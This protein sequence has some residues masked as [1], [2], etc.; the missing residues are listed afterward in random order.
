M[1][2]LLCSLLL[3]AGVTVTLPP[4]ASVSGT[5]LSL[6]AF[7]TIEG[8]D[9][10]LVARIS[11]L[12]LGYAP[13]PGFSRVLE[14]NA[15]LN[16]VRALA[17]GMAVH[18]AGAKTCRVLPMTEHIA[19][20]DIT[21][22]A[23]ASLEQHL[24]GRGFG[25]CTLELVSSAVA[26]EVPKGNSACVLEVAPQPERPG[27][28]PA[29]VAVRLIVDGQTYRTA[30]TSWKVQ[31]WRQQ[32]VLLRDVRAGEVIAADMIELRRVPIDAGLTASALDSTQ[33]LGTAAARPLQAGKMLLSSD[34]VRPLVVKQGDLVIL[35]VESG[36]I[37][38]RTSATAE[39]AG[40]VG[41][42]IRVIVQESGREISALVVSR[43][44][45]RI[46][47]GDRQPT[48]ERQ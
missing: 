16:Q 12:K 14:A 38:V 1:I 26:I 9:A 18:L 22:A 21:K 46:S 17:P 45:V 35:V 40:A 36:A 31:S 25:D 41:D 33:V 6:G 19:A 28:S 20:E 27:Y 11:A 42:R 2:T 29:L 48:G 3:S 4:Q 43:E 37:R 13:A 30:H 23:R 7:A 47:L 8:D 5:E 39:Q 24:A 34:L 44:T 15:L 32:P 10:E